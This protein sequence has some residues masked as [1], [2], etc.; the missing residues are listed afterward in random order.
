MNFSIAEWCVEGLYTINS[1]CVGTL[2][3]GD[4][5]IY[6]V[7]IPYKY[8]TNFELCYVS[9]AKISQTFVHEEQSC[10]YSRFVLAKV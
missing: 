4:F 10:D 2:A 7:R 5:E 6:T 1:C 9:S 3:L 8:L